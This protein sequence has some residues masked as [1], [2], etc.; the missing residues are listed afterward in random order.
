MED[1]AV[2][3]P[4][5]QA[6]DSLQDALVNGDPACPP[7]IRRTQMNARHRM[8]LSPEGMRASEKDRIKAQSRLCGCRGSNFRL[9]NAH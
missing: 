8:N 7:F 6:I 3:M 9:S 5:P 2:W 4:G 1:E